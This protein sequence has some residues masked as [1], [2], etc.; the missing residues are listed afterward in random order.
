MDRLGLDD[1]NGDFAGAF[2]G[3]R[4]LGWQEL[5]KSKR[6]PRVTQDDKC[7]FFSDPLSIFNWRI[8]LVWR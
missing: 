7:G 5:I 4:S 1:T 8:L 2:G 3:H 6:A